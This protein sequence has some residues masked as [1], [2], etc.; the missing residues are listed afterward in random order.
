MTVTIAATG[1]GGTSTLTREAQEAIAAADL[2][3]GAARM[4]APYESSG[5]TLFRSYDP[6]AIAERLRTGTERTAAV[7]VSGDT[8]FFS[9][10]KKLLPLLTGM[11]VQVLPGIASPVYLCART[12]HSWERLHCVTLHG[13]EGSI[14]VHVR[15]HPLTCFLLGGRITASM[16]CHRLQDFGLSSVHMHIGMRL[17]CPEEQI[18]Q[19]TP[20]DFLQL[21]PEPL[22]TVL[23]ENPDF[24]PY[25]PAG[26]PDSAFLRAS[27]P[28][29]KSE[30]RCLAVSS[31]CIAPDDIVWDIGCGTGSVTT[32]LAL[33]CPD[34]HVYAID[35]SPEAVRLT[36]EN[37][38]RFSCDNVTVTKGTFPEIPL[39][40]PGKVFLG[41]TGGSL[42]QIAAAV[43]AANPAARIVLT[44]VTLETLAAAQT[45]FAQ[46]GCTC[47]V[48]QIAV[49][50]T[51]RLGSHTLL[52]A[53]NPVF[54][55]TVQPSGSA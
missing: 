53:E 23:I 34:G 2:L 50:R 22:C 45:V 25:L 29:T 28:M 13:T 30:V 31:L 11:D 39:P 15:S 18:L 12:G 37:L 10:A 33:R 16:L 5:K 3:I 9:A 24:C 21:P 36:L 19:G 26:I 4:L 41:G 38:R 1:M 14:A 35:R 51:K 7:L 8:G 54:L 47:T 44:A 52:Q 20:A 43:Y 17:G 55:I 6:A 42:Q 48:T 27:V 46:R 32:E 40:P 49:T